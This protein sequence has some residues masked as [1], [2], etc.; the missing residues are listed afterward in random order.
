MRVIMTGG[1]TGGHIYPAIAI[2]DEIKDRDKETQILFV[3]AQKGLEKTLVPKRGYPIELLTLE[4]FDRK[5]IVR[6]IGVIR[7]LMKGNARAR[8]IIKT[9][10]PDFVVGTGGYASAPVVK[11]AQKEGV[12][13]YIHEQNAV[14]GVT[15]KLLEKHVRKIFLGFEKASEHFRNKDK[16]IVTGNPVRGEFLNATREESRREL[17]FAEDDFVLLAFG[18]S[19]GAGKIN[20]AML[21]VISE[22]NSDEKFKICL[23]T[24]SYYNKA[25]LSELS[26]NGIELGDNVV[27]MEFIDDMA[28]YLAAADLVIS[29]SGAL[30]VAEVAVSGAPT[31][32]IPSPI[33]TDNHQYYNAMA[34]AEKGGAFVFEEK[35]LEDKGRLIEAIKNLRNNPEMLKTMSEKSRASGLRE[36]TKVICDTILEDYADE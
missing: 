21:S 13:T 16:Q 33:V 8:E 17:G 12:P 24:G 27:V 5:N 36:A 14:P 22:F 15:N 30:T 29:R 6:N 31:I 7:K 11:M 4:G 10:R 19:Q 32:F 28:S 26:E 1:G 25:I 2:A 20:K 35:N 23:G 34:L 9:F 3:G 18:G